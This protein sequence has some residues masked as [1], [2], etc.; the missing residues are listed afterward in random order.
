M[1]KFSP[2][3][4]KLIVLQKKLGKKLFSVST[5]AGIGCPYARDCK[6]TATMGDNG[7]LHI[8]D[9]PHTQF[10]CFSASQ[11]VIFPKVYE[12]R[13]HNLQLIRECK[14]DTDKIAQLLSDSL[15][16]KAEIIRY[17]ISGDWTTQNHFDAALEVARKH[18]NIIFYAYT[19]SLP[20][21][22]ARLGV[23][24]SNFILTASY[25]GYRDDLI[26]KH[27]LRYV[28]VVYSKYEARKLKLPIDHDDSH[29]VKNSGNFALLIH[30][31][32]PAGSKAG[33]AVRKLDGVGSYGKRGR[34]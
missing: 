6:S 9:G 29:A 12:Q 32:Q 15:P 17:H 27:S 1:L 23:I 2:A 34:K 7:R 4:A 20:F 19:K 33:K 8:V 10:R 3:N 30:G 24:P 22:V 5:L 28:K 25:G 13:S 16:V 21:W 18:P 31:I 11:E 14:N 26:E